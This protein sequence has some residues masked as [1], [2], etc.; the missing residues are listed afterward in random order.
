MFEKFDRLVDTLNKNMKS[1]DYSK[2]TLESYNRTW[3]RFR[4]SMEKHGYE[5]PSVEAVIDFKS[6]LD[7]GVTT[8]ALYLNHIKILNDF[9]QENGIMDESFYNASLNPNK[10]KVANAR[11]KPYEH[12]FDEEAISALLNAKR[13][14]VGKK[15]SSWIRDKAIVTMILTS[16]MRNIEIRNLTLADLDFE[17]GQIRARVTKGDKP[18]VVPFPQIAQRAVN[19]YLESGFRPSSVKKNDFLFG[20]TGR[21][22]K[23]EWH[24]FD[25]ERLSRAIYNY[26]AGILGEQYAGRS[27]SLR[28]GFASYCLTEGVPLEMIGETLGHANYSTTQIYAKRLDAS[29]TTKTIGDTFSK[30]AIGG[31]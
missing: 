3:N 9:A 22:C 17:N 13:P 29:Q 26:T 18:R 10:K 8:L 6:D 31:A 16:G 4:D 5:E 2:D 30:L 21:G 11:N 24:G 1:G 15:Y 20:S 12:V 23:G 19:E 25:R 7:V 28:H 27:H 14:V